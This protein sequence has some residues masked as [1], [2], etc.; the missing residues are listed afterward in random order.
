VVHG[1]SARGGHQPERVLGHVEIAPS[2]DP[3]LPRPPDDWFVPTLLRVAEQHAATHL[4][5]E[6][7]IAIVTGL[8]P[9][10]GPREGRSKRLGRYHS[11][12][13]V[14]PAG[15]KVP[16]LPTAEDAITV[17]ARQKYATAGKVEHRRVEVHVR[18]KQDAM[19]SQVPLGV[20]ADEIELVV[21]NDPLPLTKSQCLDNPLLPF[22]FLRRIHRRETECDGDRLRQACPT[23]DRHRDGEDERGVDSAGEADVRLIKLRYGI[24]HHSL[25]SLGGWFRSG[26]QV[27]SVTTHD[28]PRQDLINGRGEV[29]LLQ[30]TAVQV[31]GSA[32]GINW[33]GPLMASRSVARYLHPQIPDARTVEVIATDHQCEPATFN[34]WG[35]SVSVAGNAVRLNVERLDEAELV[36]PGLGYFTIHLLATEAAS[37]HGGA[38]VGPT[39]AAWLLL[40][41]KLSGKST[42]LGLLHAASWRVLTDDLIVLGDGMIWPGPRSIDLRLDVAELVGLEGDVV[43]DARLRLR[44]PPTSAA[45]LG[46]VIELDAAAPNQPE[47]VPATERVRRL[48]RHSVDGPLRADPRAYLDLLA[49]PFIV[50]Q[51]PRSRTVDRLLEAM[52]AA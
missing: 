28:R 30:T 21:D 6:P 37:L 44:L 19:C 48:A 3:L 29:D 39:G 20:R 46:G 4:R 40:G 31:A 24:E 36:H 49:A 22:A 13:R 7:L 25:E 27:P 17:E 52:G 2:G 10:Q 43:R 33:R 35:G 41:T 1:R 14:Q 50:M 38:F 45:P 9:Q 32:Y 51:P 15:P 18:R 8:P 26:G 5:H 23:G 16:V 12:V 11:L 47:H 34:A 42:A